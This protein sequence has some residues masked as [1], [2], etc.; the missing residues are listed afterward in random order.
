MNN[1]WTISEIQ[2]LP[3]FSHGISLG[4]IYC[5]NNHYRMQYSTC[6]PEQ[7]VIVCIISWSIRKYMITEV[8]TVTPL[9]SIQTPMGQFRTGPC[10]VCLIIER[11]LIRMYFCI[12]IYVAGRVAL[13]SSSFL[14]RDSWMY[15]AKVY[16]IICKWA[17][18]YLLGCIHLPSC[19]LA[20]DYII[21][22]YSYK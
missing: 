19:Q 8:C 1:W 4:L 12:H 22:L 7:L 14:E 17:P 18:L 11:C 3:L 9:Q 16:Y 5:T 2:W 15:V 21:I 10:S 13:S 6:T 20:A